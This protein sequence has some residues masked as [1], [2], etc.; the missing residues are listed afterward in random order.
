MVTR[1]PESAELVQLYLRSKITGR[2]DPSTQAIPMADAYCLLNGE[3]NKLDNARF[4]AEQR[5]ARIAA[6]SN[7]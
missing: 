7:K 3:E 4:E 1:N 2:G 6:L 5:E